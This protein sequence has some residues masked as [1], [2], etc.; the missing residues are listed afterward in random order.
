MPYTRIYSKKKGQCS[1]PLHTYFF[2]HNPTQCLSHHPNQPSL[3]TTTTIRKILQ[4]QS[5]QEGN[6]AQMPSLLDPT[7]IVQIRSKQWLTREKIH[8][9]CK[10]CTLGHFASPTLSSCSLVFACCGRTERLNIHIISV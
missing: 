8:Q 9:Y 4:R 6:D 5:L 2:K 3:D 10:N 7:T 1:L